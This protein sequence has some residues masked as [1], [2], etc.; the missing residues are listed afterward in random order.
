[1][2]IVNVMMKG[3]LWQGL[4]AH[5]FGPLGIILSASTKCTTFPC[6][7]AWTIPYVKMHNVKRERGRVPIRDLAQAILRLSTSEDKT[8]S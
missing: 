8:S 3:V 7:C 6:A 4:L 5:T 1:M 2:V